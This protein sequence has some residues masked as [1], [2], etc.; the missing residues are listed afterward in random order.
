M[1]KLDK[2]KAFILKNSYSPMTQLIFAS[3]VVTMALTTWFWTR[4]KQ[5]DAVT[6]AASMAQAQTDAIAIGQSSVLH[7]SS[8]ET[9]E[10][11]ARENP[12]HIGRSSLTGALIQDS[13]ST[14][15][16]LK[17]RKDLKAQKLQTKPKSL[18]ALKSRLRKAQ[19][20]WLDD[21]TGSES[22]GNID[23]EMINVEKLSNNPAARKL[24]EEIVRDFENQQSDTYEGT[25]EIDSYDGSEK[26]AF[27]N[28]KTLA[29][30]KKLMTLLS[31]P[32][33]VAA[34]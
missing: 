3:F 2:T 13:S 8:R 18:L 5:S 11:G 30:W 24:L 32:A 28:T 14:I 9:L 21:P 22:L 26:F 10:V 17:V 33:E 1:D 20:Y 16:R 34:E 4:Q 7:G 31:R 19:S 25:T 15:G 12:V 6:E 27:N 29:K 23:V